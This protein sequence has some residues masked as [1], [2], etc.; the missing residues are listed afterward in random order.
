MQ[1][2]G[3]QGPGSCTTAYHQFEASDVAE[4]FVSVYREGRRTSVLV[5][6]RLSHVDSEFINRCLDVHIYRILG[7]T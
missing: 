7:A 2:S 5:S 6:Q 4:P 1:E 3:L